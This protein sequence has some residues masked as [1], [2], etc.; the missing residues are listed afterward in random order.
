MAFKLKKYSYNSYLNQCISNWI[1]GNEK[2]ETL[3]WNFIQIG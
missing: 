3:E 1:F 2:Q